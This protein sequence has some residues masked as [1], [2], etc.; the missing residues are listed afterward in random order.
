MPRVNVPH[1]HLL[2]WRDSERRTARY[3]TVRC[4]PLTPQTL[5]GKEADKLEHAND[6]QRMYYIIEKEP[7]VNAFISVPKHKGRLNCAAYVAGMIEAVLCGSNFV[8]RNCDPLLDTC[9]RMPFFL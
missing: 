2:K 3:V 7:L 5:F 6:D 8:S 9:L 4:L 1:I